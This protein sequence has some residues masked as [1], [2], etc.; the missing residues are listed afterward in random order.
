[1]NEQN[2]PMSELPMGF[3]MALAMQPNAMQHYAT[4]SSG[5]QNEI[6]TRAKA[7]QSKSEMQ[8]LVNSLN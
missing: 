7:V 2:N 6:L 3:A 5:Q 1:M 4:L 8:S